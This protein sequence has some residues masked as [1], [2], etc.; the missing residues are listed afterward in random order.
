MSEAIHDRELG[1]HRRISRRDFLNGMAVSIAALGG[2]NVFG[3]PA[4]FQGSVHAA[5]NFSGSYPPALTGMR[6]SQPGSYDAAHSLRDGTFWESA[7]SPTDTGESYDL[8]VVGGGISGLAA[9]YFYRKQAGKNAR[10]LILDNHDDFGGHARRNEFRV[11]KRLLLS[12]GGT[13]SIESP[14]EYSEVAK[15]VLTELG[16]ETKLFYKAYDQKLYSH[17]NTACFFDKQTFGEDRLVPGMGSLTWAEFL[18]KSPLSEKVRQEILRLYTEKKDYLPGLSREEKQARLKTISYANFLTEICKADP[19]VLPFFQSYTHDLFAVGI[20]AIS[21][22]ACYRNPDDYGGYRYAGFDGLNLGED[23]AGESEEPY[24]FHFPDGNASI[25]RLLVRS[26]IPECVPGHTMEDVVSARADYSKLDQPSRSI[27]LRLNSTAVRAQQSHANGSAHEVEV[28]YVQKGKLQTV[29]GKAC[30]LACY[31]MMVPY[32]CP[33]L[34]EKQKEALHYCVK[35]PFIYTHVAIRNWTAFHKLA[36]RQIISPGSYHCL[37]MLDFPVSLG[38]YQFPSSPQEPMILFMLRTPCQPGL[39]RREQYRMGRYELIGT[40]FSTFERNIREQLN[41]MLASGG[42]DSA[43]DIAAITVNRW[44][45]GYA[46][47]YDSLSDPNWT[48]EDRPCVVGRKQFGRISIANSDAGAS[49]YTNVA[50]DQAYRAVQEQLK[51][52]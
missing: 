39:P 4:S 19:G 12:N 34:P 45:H 14:S 44:A 6:G 28:A 26:L 15:G 35:E 50:I 32:L 20:D 36:I 48:P 22:E 3:L 31:N 21:A 11:G 5:N 30:I 8:I 9:A 16:I 40:A 38:T 25:A 37:T 47:E 51:S 42:F 7:G 2:A 23:D 29:K 17:L 27:R 18:S 52:P 24:I 13:Q 10:I 46:Y 41:R 33:H 49:A 1:M 43:R